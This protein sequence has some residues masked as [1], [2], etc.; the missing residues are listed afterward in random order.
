MNKD[1]GM[2]KWAPYK[3]LIE[4]EEY[5]AKMYEENEKIEKPKISEEVAEEI[6]NILIN[7]GGEEIIVGYYRNRKINEKEG[8]IKKI[9][10]LEKKIIIYPKTGIY[11]NEIISLKIK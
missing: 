4:Q 1:R 2:K 11:F 6:N 9:D 5:L 10:L 8:I 3:S 7:Y